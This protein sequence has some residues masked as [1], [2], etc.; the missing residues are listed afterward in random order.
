MEDDNLQG[1]LRLLFQKILEPNYVMN[2]YYSDGLINKLRE[3]DSEPGMEV[4]L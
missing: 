1:K 4:I 2:N 3:K